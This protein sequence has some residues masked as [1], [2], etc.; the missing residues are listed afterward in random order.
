M[1]QFNPHRGIGDDAPQSYLIPKSAGPDRAMANFQCI[2]PPAINLRKP[3]LLAGQG[4]KWL[5]QDGVRALVTLGIL[6]LLLL[7]HLN[8]LI[9]LQFHLQFFFQTEDTALP[10]ISIFGCVVQIL[11]QN[12][13]SVARMN[14]FIFDSCISISNLDCLGSLLSYHYLAFGHQSK[15]H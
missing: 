12:I 4:T 5:S 2:Y 13:Y 15:A 1:D 10:V 14:Q 6:V 7:Y 8:V 9:L 3:S 11:P